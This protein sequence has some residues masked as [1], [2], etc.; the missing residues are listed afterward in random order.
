MLK[1]LFFTKAKQAPEIL[2]RIREFTAGFSKKPPVPEDQGKIVRNII[3]ELLHMAGQH[4]LW[5][6]ASEDEMEMANEAI[7]KYLM[8][9]IFNW[10]VSWRNFRMR[11]NTNKRCTRFFFDTCFFSCFSPSVDDLERDKAIFRTFASLQFIT[12]TH[13]DINE[14]HHDEEKFQ[15]AIEGVLIRF[16][17]SYTPHVLTSVLYDSEIRK[18]NAYKAPRDKLVCILNACKIIY[19]IL[20]KASSEGH[21]AG[22]DEFL[23]LLIYV[24]LKSNPPQMHSNIQYILRFRNPSKMITEAG[25]Y[26]THVESAIDFIENV[27]PSKLTIDPAEFERFVVPRIKHQSSYHYY[28]TICIQG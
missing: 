7:E 26:F 3:D 13:L 27:N 9:K 14:R 23:P 5:R 19:S 11:N 17:I 15:Q 24:V 21:A 18:I 8:T 2:K 12:P 16:H 28:N 20:N 22:A 6:G 25:Y 4:K 10:F 1:E